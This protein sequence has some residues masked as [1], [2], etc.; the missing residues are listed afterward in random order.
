[1]LITAVG[2]VGEV[3]VVEVVELL[4]SKFDLAADSLVLRRVGPV[5]FLVFMADEESASNLANNN[6]SPAD[7]G[8]IRLHCRRWS[9]FINASSSKLP[10]LV[11]I[12]LMGVPAHA[13]EVST[14]ETLLNP[15]GWIKEVHASTRNREDYST[16]RVKAWCLNTGVIPP[17]RDLIIVE[18][19]TGGD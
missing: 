12:D 19:P 2:A 15:Y 5:E 14:T 8:V 7:N 1:M 4:A 11:D 13:W 18:P 17:R 9:R 10:Q 3:L 6:D 16:F